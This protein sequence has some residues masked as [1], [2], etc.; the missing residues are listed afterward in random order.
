MW[1][2]LLVTVSNFPL[3]TLCSIWENEHRSVPT[4]I[5]LSH[6]FLWYTPHENL[7]EASYVYATLLQCM[8]EYMFLNLV[9]GTLFKTDKFHYG[10]LSQK[11]VSTCS[12]CFHMCSFDFQHCHLVYNRTA[13]LCV[14][15]KYIH[16]KPSSAFVVIFLHSLLQGALIEARNCRL[17]SFVESTITA[18]Q[19]HWLLCL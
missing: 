18:T 1:Y 12:W 9:Q 14:V 6:D 15:T 10:S 16:A 11:R 4:V 8:F 5:F 17:K 13:T 7:Y 2:I 19:Q 3:V